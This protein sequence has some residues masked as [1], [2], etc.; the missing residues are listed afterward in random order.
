MKKYRALVGFA[1]STLSMYAGE[2]KEIS[3]DVADEFVRI[4]YI[5]PI[6]D[7]G[8]NI[9]NEENV[10]ETDKNQNG[11]E[12]DANQDDNSENQDDEDTDKEEE[13]KPKSTTKRRGK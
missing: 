10:G 8:E 6:S 1:G 5:V 2:V 13:I 4:G 11:N 12:N 3:D 9:E 7:S